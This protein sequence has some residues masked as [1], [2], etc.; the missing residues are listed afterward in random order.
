MQRTAGPVLLVIYR[1]DAAPDP[2]T[3][4]VV[5]DDVERYW[6]WHAP[7][8]GT[9]WISG[10]RITRRPEVAR[11]GYGRSTSRHGADGGRGTGLPAY[12]L[13]NGRCAG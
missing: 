13:G 8:G 6:Y 12:R 2:V 11:A 10:Q 9:G 3:G 4:K 7:D 1:A 5:N